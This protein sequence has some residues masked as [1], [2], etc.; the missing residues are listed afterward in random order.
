[1]NF[2]DYL[3]IKVWSSTLNNLSYINKIKRCKQAISKIYSLT[4]LLNDII[5]LDMDDKTSYN[6]N[7]DLKYT[8]KR[9]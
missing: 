1:M 4:L 8:S 2:I 7:K 9:I 5:S 6:K 3:C